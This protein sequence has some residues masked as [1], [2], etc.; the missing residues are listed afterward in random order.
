MFSA[1]PVQVALSALLL[2]AAAVSGCSG[3]QE[4]AAP[5][6]VES[7]FTPMPRGNENADLVF[8][9]ADERFNAGDYFGAQ[10]EF[11]TLFIV[12]PTYRGGVPEQGLR[13][14]CERAGVDCGL[15]IGRL[16]I[17]REVFSNRY[18]NMD[19]W[20]PQQRRDYF[21]IVD[22]Y[23]RAL[24][25]DYAGAVSVGGA[26]TSSPD[27]YFASS[28][29]RC[30]DSASASLAAIERQR[31]ADAALLVW[32]DNAPC[33]NQTRLQLLDAFGRDDWE[34]FVDIYPQYAVCA[35]ALNAI[36]D[37]GVLSGDPRLGMEH[38][39]AWSDMS[40]IEAL[41]EDYGATYEATRQALVELSASPDYNRMVVEWNNL[42]FEENRLQNQISS[43][44]VAR[45]ALTGSNRA[46]VEA[47]L[48][49]LEEQLVQ[50][51]RQRRDV[52]V[53][54]NALRRA[55]GLQPRETP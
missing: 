28:A 7:P 22:C 16:E 54:V 55:L 38:D 40:E 19:A 10:R 42:G 25:G 52:L 24:S 32:F 23:E 21:A 12:A 5:S 14:T 41:M 35:D 27:P 11:G 47:Q 13:A 26:V 9:D 30:A 31:Q 50:V 37:A 46:Q 29:R 36:I 34:S 8:L 43:L 1:R 39:V 6:G 51:R 44:Q 48:G 3:S 4:S 45:D 2:S 18:G 33:M 49:A 53:G 20:V 15:V 17:M